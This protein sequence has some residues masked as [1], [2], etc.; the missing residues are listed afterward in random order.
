MHPFSYVAA[1]DVETA[2]DLASRRERTAFLAGGTNLLDLMKE[3]V[4]TP[5]LLIDV[6]G[7][8]SLYGVSESPDAIRIGALETMSDVAEHPAI[9]RDMPVIREAL[10]ASASPQ[11]RNMATIA[12]NVLQRTR[13]GYFRDTAFA[14]NKRR[15][16][17]GCPAVEGVSRMHAILGTSERCIASHPSDLS[18]ALIAVDAS[19]II[20]S[21]AG[22]RMM[23]LERFYQ[24]PA[25]SPHIEHHLAHGE[26][27]VA[28][29]IPR[30]RRT[31]ASHYLKV[32]DRASYEFALVS[33]AV[34][35]EWNGEIVSDVRVAFGGIGTKPWRSR[36]AEDEL[37]GQIPS[38][39]VLA[40]AGAAAT[41]GAT[42]T[43]HNAFKIGLT[44]RTLKRAI[45]TVRS[46]R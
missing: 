36:E 35:V 8:P 21:A 3:Q 31:R 29:D 33:A 46:L 11:L 17:S 16:G 15:P 40:R 41:R 26:L 1:G 5:A 18:V 28:V 45:E 38:D 4:L 44:A 27:I 30:A 25:E 14:C 23:P 34:A 13:C 42:T 12:G 19:L 7:I 20:R 22:E 37:R 6:R 2:L 39:A 9:V 32:R 24:T 10:L 43:Q